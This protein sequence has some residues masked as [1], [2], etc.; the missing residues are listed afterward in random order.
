MMMLLIWGVLLVCLV[1]VVTDVRVRR[2]PNGL[3]VGLA[4]VALAVH[5]MQG[6]ISL[7]IS[8][9]VLVAVLLGG[10][11]A[12]SF[13]WFGGGDVKL[14]AAVAAAFSY[15]DA[16]AFVI[17]ASIA[18]GVFAACYALATGRLGT[19]MHNVGLLLRPLA[20]QGTVAAAPVSPVVF[21]YATAIAAGAIA[22]TLSH[23]LMPFLRLPV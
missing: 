22:V 2:I 6:W 11:V 12:F 17:Y 9:M 16:V 20:Y 14:A 13:G 1:A 8:F 21:P 10:T 5:A 15:P 3:T 19:V 7:L 18:G 23:T 4:V